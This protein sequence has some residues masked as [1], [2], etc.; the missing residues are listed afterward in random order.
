MSGT[1]LDASDRAERY[2]V[3]RHIIVGRGRNKVT[4]YYGII[5]SVCRVKVG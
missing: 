4:K 5:N 3:L 2:P 1:V